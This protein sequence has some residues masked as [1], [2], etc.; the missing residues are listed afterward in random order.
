MTWL[1]PP[2]FGNGAGRDADAGFAFGFAL[3]FRLGLTFGF[4]LAIGFGAAFFIV[5]LACYL[6]R[7]VP[8]VT[9]VPSFGSG[10]DEILTRQLQVAMFETER[11][12]G[13]DF[14]PDRLIESLRPPFRKFQFVTAMSPEHASRVLEE[15]VEPPRKWGWPTSRK[16]GYFEGKVAGGRFK[17]HRVIRYQN[18]FLPIIEGNFRREGWRTIVTL[19]IRLVWPVVLFWIG[20]ILFLASSSIAVDSRLGGPLGVRIVAMAMAVFIYLVATV[21]F[22]VEVRIAMQRL[23]GL[24]HTGSSGSDLRN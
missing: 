3:T 14:E 9:Q 23:L 15:I 10:D 2:V 18:A 12:I 6:I 1:T 8:P 5:V 7:V 17:F 13:A 11:I 20:I 22:A 21:S 19:N 24:L 16:R 4:A